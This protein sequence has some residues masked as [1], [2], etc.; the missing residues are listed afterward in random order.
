MCPE[1]TELWYPEYPKVS[2]GSL[3]TWRWQRRRAP[4]DFRGD[5]DRASAI[6]AHGAHGKKMIVG[7]YLFQN[8]FACGGRKI[9]DGPTSINGLAPQKH[10]TRADGVVPRS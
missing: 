2:R 10:E 3:L 9:L 4:L 8:C 6:L 5:G 7:G 1:C